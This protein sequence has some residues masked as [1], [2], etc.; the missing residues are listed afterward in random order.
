MFEK[1]TVMAQLQKE[2]GEKMYQ[3]LA[4]GKSIWEKLEKEVENLPEGE[5]LYDCDQLKPKAMK[6]L[7]DYH[8]KEYEL[9]KYS[10]SLG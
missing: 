1:G 3:A 2:H 9:K 8:Q 5:L 10:V 4:K 7:A 6:C